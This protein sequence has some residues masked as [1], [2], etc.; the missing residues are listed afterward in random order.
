[1]SRTRSRAALAASWV[2][3]LILTASCTTGPTPTVGPLTTA[4]IGDAAS[5]TP[6]DNAAASSVPTSP[7]DGVLLHI[8]ATGLSDVTGFTLRLTSGREITFRIG[9]LENGDQFP[10]GHLAEHLATASPI[11]VYFRVDGPD[12]VVYRLEDAPPG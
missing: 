8:D 1:M 5:A 3:V 4:S 12:L 9:T 11:R 2:A 7:V 6:A 10:P